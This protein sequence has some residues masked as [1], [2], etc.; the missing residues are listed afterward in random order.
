VTVEVS[1]WLLDDG[2]LVALIRD[3][4]DRARLREALAEAE[5]RRSLATAAGQ[6]GEWAWHIADG[7]VA[8]SP[9]LE[10]MRG[11][12]PGS[13]DG[14]FDAY[15]RDIHPGDRGRVLKQIQTAVDERQTHHVEYR[16]K[17]PD[18]VVRRIEERG[19]LTYD[20]AG[21]PARLVG[22]CV[23]VT[24]RREAERAL[25]AVGQAYHALL[26]DAPLATVV[27]QLDGAVQL[28]NAAAERLLGWRAEDVVGRPDP[29]VPDDAREEQSRH[30]Q[31]LILGETLSRVE[32]Q[33]Q[34]TDGTRVDVAMWAAPVRDAGGLVTG[35]LVLL[36]EVGERRRQE[37]HRRQVQTMEAVGRL[38]GGLAHDFNNMLTAIEGHS[39]MLLDE[40]P[41]GDARDSAD[42]IKK[43]A[44]R[45]AFL[46]Q[47]LL[48][49]SR[50]QVHQ[51]Q[52]LDLNALVERALPTLREV[53]GEGVAVE[54]TL[55]PDL[56]H[57]SA[58]PAQ[59][60]QVL[61]NLALN[62]RE[63]TGGAGT[64]TLETANVDGA[65]LG[66][67]GVSVA[68]G[69]YVLLAVRDS[70]PGMDEQTQARCFEP[71]FTTK[72]R[73]R[74]LGLSTAYG[75]V[76]Q[77]GGYIW[78][79]GRPGQGATIE[80]YLPRA[81]GDARPV[82]AAARARSAKGSE[83]VLLVEQ[84]ESV[85]AFV[86]KALAKAGYTVLTAESEEA[87][88]AL[89]AERREPI[90]LVITDLVMPGTTGGRALFER[91]TELRP[92]LRALYISSHADWDPARRGAVDP[93]TAFLQKPFTAPEL[94][95]KV[96]E[97]LDA[98]ARAR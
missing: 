14:T 29:S 36:E 84:E 67:Q 98:P 79:S 52:V 34:R 77:S 70:G 65:A 42:E 13:F 19:E 41:P 63:A 57:V 81:E 8:W 24:E 90:H 80:I 89:C 71:F 54:A 38:A 73:G 26:R 97:V 55:A 20:A 87:A 88:E 46:T 43:A 12:A 51:P 6:M 75:I 95:R 28:W 31:S 56:G 5:L 59:L 25:Q 17:R 50:M 16:V 49:F 47:Q 2:R 68:P 15:L 74:G 82:A 64:L 33:R 53:V 10:A 93:R 35:G 58:D 94:A 11:L 76:K 48:A 83:T 32:T 78:A 27:V 18:G 60:E 45:A 92:N 23:D 1:A 39:G 3:A 96:R 9:A 61:R 21:A 37:V 62:A 22:V 91:L 86:R 40:L 44:D 69:R 66:R 72:G 7:T 4:A 30:L 85:R